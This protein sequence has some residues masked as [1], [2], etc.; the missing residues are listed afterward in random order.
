MKNY[1]L[2][3]EPQTAV[4]EQDEITTLTFTNEKIKGQ[5]EI[6]KISADDNELTGEEKGTF[7]KDA[8]FEVYTETD[9]LV[10]TITILGNGKGI[11]KLLK[12]RKI[13]C[14]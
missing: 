12:Y 10:D 13:L 3:E 7:L 6:T 2:N 4:L 1:V 9:E 8:V 14:D 11:S 5:I